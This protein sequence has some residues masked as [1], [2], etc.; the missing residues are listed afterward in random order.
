MLIE[1][2]VESVEN[3]MAA[4][5]GGAGRVELCAALRPPG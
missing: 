4:E 3:A 5:A 2:C 1:A